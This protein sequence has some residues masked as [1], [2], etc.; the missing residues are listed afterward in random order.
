MF[1][2]IASSPLNPAD[3]W[4]SL[5]VTSVG[6]HFPFFLCLLYAPWHHCSPSRVM[7]KDPECPASC[8]P[9]CR[10]SL[11]WTGRVSASLTSACLSPPGLPRQPRPAFSCRAAGG[12]S[13]LIAG[14]CLLSLQFTV[15]LTF[16]AHAVS[17]P[18]E[19]SQVSK[20]LNSRLHDIASAMMDSL[21]V[22]HWFSRNA[23]VPMAVSC[24]WPAAKSGGPAEGQLQR[25]LFRETFTGL[26]VC[27]PPGCFG[28]RC[29]LNATVSWCFSSAEVERQG[30]FS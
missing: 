7:G 22:T 2:P 1:S 10:L 16:K 20:S 29:L 24:C 30:L 14:S 21:L 27:L 12:L 9:T 17:L 19:T 5:L 3:S 11:R 6:I 23:W 26:L 4:T 25:C 15:D 13:Q 28:G 18:S 8:F